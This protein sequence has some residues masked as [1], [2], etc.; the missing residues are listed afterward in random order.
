VS[1]LVHSIDPRTR[2]CSGCGM[3][4]VVYFLTRRGTDSRALREFMGDRGWHMHV[5]FNVNDHVRVRLTERGL[6]IL[7]EKQQAFR[8]AFPR[9]PPDTLPYG[10]P[11][12][13]AAGWSEWQM[14]SLM[15]EFGEHFGIGAEPPFKTEI[16]FVVPD[17][18]Q[19]Q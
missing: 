3:P 2:C 10:S 13:D 4:E 5:K 12:T 17:R 1:C 18:E 9:V 8:A 6:A 15:A 14:W 7:R 19:P 11:K 16:E